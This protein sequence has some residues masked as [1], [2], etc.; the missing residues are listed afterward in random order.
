MKYTRHAVSVFL[1]LVST[2]AVS[3][4]DSGSAVS[5]APDLAGNAVIDPPGSGPAPV[6]TPPQ[7][8]EKR[9]YSTDVLLF[10]GT[11]VWTSEV[12]ALQGIL[13]GH[14]LSYDLVNSAQLDAMTADDLAKYGMILWPGG[15]GSMQAASIT[16]GERTALREA[17]QSRGVGFL[18]FCAGAFMAVNPLAV[19]DHPTLNYYYL[20]NQ[21]VDIAMT[22][23]T[24]ADG[25]TRDVLWYGGPVT[26]DVSGG[27]IAKYPTGDPA[28]TE[29]W[30]G[31]GFVILSGGHPS[32][33]ESVKA[34][35]GMQDSDGSDTDLAWSL[36]N[37]VL[38]QKALPAY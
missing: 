38:T 25:S 35:L 4:C 28:I 14:G 10:N 19:V 3:A 12:S 24:F 26:P 22:L 34:S 23:Y 5:G 29:L 8:P 9:G 32:V 6:S 13:S 18:G 30:S 7:A 21:G 2:L 20:E 1:I 31:K 27:V 36:I 11:G 17:V 33:S 15:S 16:S 37:S